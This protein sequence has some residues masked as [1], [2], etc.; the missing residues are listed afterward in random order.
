MTRR[1]PIGAEPQPDG[2]THFRVWAP[3][4]EYVEVVVGGAATLLT[5]EPD[6]HHSGLAAATDGSKYRFRLD[7]KDEFPDPASRFQ[8][9]GPHGPSQ[10]VDPSRFQWTDQSW[11]GGAMRGQV[12]YELHIG[13][14]TREGTFNA[15][16]TEL[17]EL[18]ALGITLVEMRFARRGAA[19]SAAT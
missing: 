18:A 19:Q 13:T 3:R 14:F 6:G 4:R 10:V 12:I 1:Y 5:R 8:P 2:G 9:Q 11:K 16:R 7:R 17:A 15:A